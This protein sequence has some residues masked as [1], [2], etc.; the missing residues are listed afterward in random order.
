MKKYKFTISGTEYDVH[1]KDIEDNVAEVDVN[2]T[3]Y[4]VQ[5][6]G[7]VKTSK[8]PKLIRK[9]VEQMPGE[10]QIK[11]SASTGKHKVTAPLPGTI[12][13]IN[14]SVGDVVTEGQNLMV[15]EAMK[16]ENQVQTTKGGE[17]TAIKVNVGDSVLQDDLLI[18]IA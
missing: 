8:T 9:P 18:E 17:V 3:I 16:M 5:I 1:L 14:V 2:G 4:E 7:E 13:K 12:L 10:G 15:M 11:K 6:H